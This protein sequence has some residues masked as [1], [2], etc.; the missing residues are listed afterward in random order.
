M[1]AGLIVGGQA[2]RHLRQQHGADGDADHADR[3]LVEPVGVIQRRERA[4]RQEARDDGVG[5]QRDLRARRAERRRPQRAEECADIVVELERREARQHA[6][7]SPR[8]PTS[9]SNSRKPA[10]RTPQA[11][12]WP[13]SGKNAASASVA[14]ID[15]LSKI[16]AAAALAKRCI[17][18]EHAA[19]ER[20][21]RDQQQ[22]GKRDAGQLDRELA[23]APDRR[24]IPA[25]AWRSPA[26]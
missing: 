16:G 13:A 24:K 9:R 21:Q 17:D 10:I 26:A 8:P 3:Q 5:E 14:I 15:R 7:A 1:R 20:H 6:A 11:A 2:A 18:I 25:P 23:A 4:R 22:I 19:I 12:A